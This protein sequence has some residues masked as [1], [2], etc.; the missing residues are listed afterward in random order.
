MV[1]LSPDRRQQRL[2]KQL[3]RQRLVAPLERPLEPAIQQLLDNTQLPPARQAKVRLAVLHE[4]LR[5]TRVA[6]CW[7]LRLSAGDSFFKQLYHASIFKQF[8]WLLGVLVA[9]QLLTISAWFVLGR[10]ILQGTLSNTW[11]ELWALLLLTVIPLQILSLWLKNRFALQQGSL[12]RQRLLHGILQLESE[13]IRHQGSGHFLSQVIDIEALEALSLSSGLLALMAIIELSFALVI[14]AFGSGG[15]LHMSLL[16]IWLVA[17]GL[18]H[19]RYYLQMQTWIRYYREMTQDL[20]ERMIGHRTRLAQEPAEQHHTEEDQTLSTYLQLSEKLDRLDFLSQS[21]VGRHGWMLLGVLGLLPSFWAVNENFSLLIISLAGILLAANALEHLSD[22]SR[23]LIQAL[24][25]WKEL[26]MLFHAASRER[27]QP[28]AQ[29]VDLLPNKP[30]LDLQAVQFAYRDDLNPLLTGCDL[31]IET[32]QRLLLQGA[33]GGGKS[34][35][36]TLLAGL[37]QP[38]TGH[39]LLHGI[40]LN[41]LGAN[42]WQRRVVIAPQF[43]ENHLLTETLAFNLL[44]GRT[45]FPSREDLIEAE[46][47]CRELQLGELLDTM[48]A[49][50]QQMVGEG[51]WRLS[52]G[53]RSRIFIA[54]TLLQDADL[55]ILDESFAALDAETLKAALYCVLRRS[56]TLF[57]IAHP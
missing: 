4:Q 30:L 52:H 36:A 51:G 43:H 56:K 17:L 53:E 10:N 23:Q 38:Q 44:M 35:L 49:G 37:R 26:Q 47:I 57:V 29:H 20:A 15:L 14:L 31:Q 45:W 32:G 18:L 54:R 22:S 5:H 1:V 34:T 40:P 21:I 24:V 46:T 11:I 13:E 39:V 28:P 2:A 41:I 9:A 42:I 50:L 27:E 3:V 33:S 7:M 48:P 25:T 12:F 6:R 55:I 19:W 8:A 16:L